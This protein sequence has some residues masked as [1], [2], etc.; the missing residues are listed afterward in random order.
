MFRWV[1]AESDTS[2]K[3]KSLLLA[4]CESSVWSVHM[5]PTML[6]VTVSVFYL[7]LRFCDQALKQWCFYKEHVELWHVILTQSELV[8]F[9]HWAGNVQRTV[10]LNTLA[11]QMK[12]LN[13]PKVY[14][15]HFHHCWKSSRGQKVQLS[16]AKLNVLG[17]QQI[18]LHAA[19][20]PPSS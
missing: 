3:W 10:V 17:R 9:P 12:Y 13:H 18:N 14:F 19:A 1:W 5:Q 16:G 6:T 15:F 11:M 4:V 2:L 8:S 7:L 20:P